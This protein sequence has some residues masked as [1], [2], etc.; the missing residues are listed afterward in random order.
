MTS[1][2]STSLHSITVKI[3]FNFAFYIEYIVVGCSRHPNFI[4]KNPKR[5]SDWIINILNVQQTI[6]HWNIKFHSMKCFISVQ[7]NNNNKNSQNDRNDRIIPFEFRCEIDST[8]IATKLEKMSE[9][10]NKIEKHFHSAFWFILNEI[11]HLS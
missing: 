1:T 2:I 8:T 4:V 3:H 6:L 5:K 11:W 10:R 7:C 9:N